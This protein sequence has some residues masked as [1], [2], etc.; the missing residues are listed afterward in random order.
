MPLNETHSP[1]V[2]DQVYDR[3]VE[4]PVESALWNLPDLDRAVLGGAGDNFIVVRTPLE[5]KYCGLVTS[6]E[7]CISIYT[8][9]L[10]TYKYKHIHCC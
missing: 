2:G 6:Y 4:I 7:W 3:F 10:H 9:D 1:L 5:V 8:T